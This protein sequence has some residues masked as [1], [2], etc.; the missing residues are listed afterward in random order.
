MA[1]T[2]GVA[3][4]DDAPCR[5][6][7]HAEGHIVGAVEVHGGPAVAAEGGV[8]G[9]VAVQAADRVIQ[10]ICALRRITG[11]DDSTVGCEGDRIIANA[12]SA[13]RA[14]ETRQVDDDLAVAAEAV[15]QRAVWVVADDGEA[16]DAEEVAGVAAHD[17]LAVGL[18]LHVVQDV[19]GGTADVG[20]DLAIHAERG[21]ADGVRAQPQHGHFER[22][23]LRGARHGD[24]VRRADRDGGADVVAGEVE[25]GAPVA[26]KTLIKSAVNVEADD[27]EVETGVRRPATEHDAVLAVNGHRGDAEVLVA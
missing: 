14:D 27:V 6:N 13:G 17:D 24:A 26:V 5:V 10:A 25:R 22:A 21:I 7:G 2:V 15:V 23:A 11:D 4:H 9:A 19:E 12:P 16:R 1:E 20:Q 8:D 3:G 18:D